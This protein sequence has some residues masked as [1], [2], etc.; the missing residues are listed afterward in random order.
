MSSVTTTLK[1]DLTFGTGVAKDGSEYRTTAEI[2]WGKMEKQGYLII[3]EVYNE[4]TQKEGVTPVDTGLLR[5][6]WRYGL[7]PTEA[8]LKRGSDDPKGRTFPRPAP[9]DWTKLNR[10]KWKKNQPSYFIWNDQH[11][12]GIV[13]DMDKHQNFIEG[14]VSRG[15]RR[16]VARMK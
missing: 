12:T 13:N 14:A 3:Q 7:R 2:M 10:W 8:A 15:E 5:H 6:S 4:L 1:G 11:Y 16:A 9:A